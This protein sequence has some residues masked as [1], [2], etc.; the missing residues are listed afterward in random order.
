M[1]EGWEGEHDL[2]D[3]LPERKY[4]YRLVPDYEHEIFQDHN[5]VGKD[6]SSTR[7]H[8]LIQSRSSRASTTPMK[9]N[10]LSGVP[11]PETERPQPTLRGMPEEV[12]LITVEYSS[13]K[14]YVDEIF[15]FQSEY[16]S[17][18]MDC[19][20]EQRLHYD[21]KDLCH[22]GHIHLP[23]LEQLLEAGSIDQAYRDVI[24]KHS[25]GM[26][27]FDLT[28]GLIWFESLPDHW[29]KYL[30][31]IKMEFCLDSFD[32]MFKTHEAVFNERFTSHLAMCEGLESLEIHFKFDY[33]DHNEVC[34]LFRDLPEIKD[35]STLRFFV[36]ASFL[37][38]KNLKIMH[39]GPRTRCSVPSRRLIHSKQSL[40][41]LGGW[42]GLGHVRNKS[43]RNSVGEGHQI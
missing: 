6:S 36:P 21:S 1:N 14:Q 12:R 18:E 42:H 8:G 23:A 10:D 28:N 20:R 41:R 9:M 7:L 29:L 25:F 32:P 40:R 4:V 35:L 13:A 17:A 22:P 16:E 11:F 19:L 39:S 30:K 27:T 43:E 24:E 34:C 3:Y 33:N 37:P 38:M 5:I 31:H 26:K 2:P 15:W